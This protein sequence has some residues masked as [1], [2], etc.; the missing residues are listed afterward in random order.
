MKIFI[1]FSFLLIIFSSKSYGAQ[2][3]RGDLQLTD[4][5]VNSFINYIKGDTSKGKSAFN[6]PLTLWISNDGNLAYWWYCPYERCAPSSGVEEKKICE[7]ES[8]QSCSRFARGRYVRW[9]NGIN[10]KGKK[11]K[12]NSKMTENEIKNKLTELG[13]Y[14]N[15]LT[16]ETEINE[17][18]DEIIS[19][20]KSLFEQLETLTKMFKDGLISEEEF[21]KA[22][23]K[24]LN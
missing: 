1:I 2:D 19:K 13:F 14:N 3:G 22:K 23:K 24:I 7:K 18:N 12:F 17:S 20:D 9:D 11:A 15:N 10:P 21:K 16:T 5:A 8:N 4:Q 6:K